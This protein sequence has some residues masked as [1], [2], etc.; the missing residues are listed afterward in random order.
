MTLGTFTTCTTYAATKQRAAIK[1]AV[2]ITTLFFVVFFLYVNLVEAFK[3]LNIF[4]V[5]F[6][7]LPNFQSILFLEGFKQLVGKARFILLCF[8][9]IFQIFF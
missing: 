2:A 8:K 9:I 6:Y 4:I 7:Q 5:Q 3:C 1:F